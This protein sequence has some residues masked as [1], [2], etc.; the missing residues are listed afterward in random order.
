[1]LIMK[2]NCRSRGPVIYLFIKLVRI[3]FSHLKLHTH[4]NTLFVDVCFM[5]Y[6]ITRYIDN[7][8]MNKKGKTTFRLHVAIIYLR[9]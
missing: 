9:F 8:I 6:L 4:N 5:S 2:K 1:M 3:I 7:I